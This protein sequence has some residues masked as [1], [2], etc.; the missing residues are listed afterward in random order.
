MAIQKYRMEYPLNVKKR[1]LILLLVTFVPCTIL[2]SEFGFDNAFSWFVISTLGV[3][4]TASVM[5]SHR[6][7]PYLD[8]AV[9]EFINQ[10]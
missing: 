1:L 2:Y 6:I 9:A 10:R 5:E 3:Y 8:G 4:V 7:E